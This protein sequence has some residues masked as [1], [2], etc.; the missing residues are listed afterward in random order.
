[1]QSQPNREQSHFAYS[2]EGH[3]IMNA[4]QHSAG[5]CPGNEVATVWP[6]TCSEAAAD[7][8]LRLIG[9]KCDECG[10]LA[11]PSRARCVRCYGGSMSEAMLA[12]NGRVVSF[13]A[14]R[15]APPGYWG[16]V[17]YALGMIEL[18]DGVSVLAHLTG[19]PAHDWK[20]GEVVES[21]VLPVNMDSAG[22][23]AG[24]SFAFRPITGSPS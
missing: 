24:T 18:A 22:R 23:G 9:T 4:R 15:Q 7:G 21:C 20:S 12:R 13:S 10:Q 19:K 17:P 14:V 2:Q 16:P 11:F 6:G 8:S 5:E 3:Q 1:M